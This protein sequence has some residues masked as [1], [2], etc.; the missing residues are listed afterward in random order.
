[1]MLYIYSKIQL[2]MKSLKE[3]LTENLEDTSIATV[4]ENQEANENT[5]E[6][7]NINKTN[8]N[9]ENILKGRPTDEKTD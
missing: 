2:I 8:E 7:T 4:E 1:M 3:F 6:K 9:N 5:S